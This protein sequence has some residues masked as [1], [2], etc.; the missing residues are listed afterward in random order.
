MLRHEF[1]VVESECQTRCFSVKKIAFGNIIDFGG[2]TMNISG[3][4]PEKLFK[5]PL[6][7]LRRLQPRLGSIQDTC[8]NSVPLAVPFS[9]GRLHT[10]TATGCI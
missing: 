7:H 2:F 5:S 10:T 4:D 1:D 8:R 3:K 9:F 6:I